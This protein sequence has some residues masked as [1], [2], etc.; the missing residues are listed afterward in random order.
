[1]IEKLLSNNNIADKEK[2]KYMVKLEHINPSVGET[3]QDGL[4]KL[5]EGLRKLSIANIE[6]SYNNSE[7]NL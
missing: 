5:I 3:G 4:I 6:K 7:N 1:M 2:E